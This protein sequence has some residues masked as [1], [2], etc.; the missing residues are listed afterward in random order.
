MSVSKV[1]ETGRKGMADGGLR[2]NYELEVRNCSVLSY[3]ADEANIGGYGV[4]SSWL[5]GYGETP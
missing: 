1:N 3:S 5:R 4:N 2:P